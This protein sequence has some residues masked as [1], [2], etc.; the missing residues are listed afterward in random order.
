MRL[1]FF[2]SALNPASLPTRPESGPGPRISG[3]APRLSIAPPRKPVFCHFT[4]SHAQLK[5]RTFHR[6]CLPLAADGFEVR[7]LSPLHE[8]DSRSGVN[9]IPLPQRAGRWRRILDWPRLL[10]TLLRQKAALYHFQ[11][12]E[13]LPVAFVLKAVF[14]KR[15][16]YDAYEDFPSMARQTTS[17]PHV[18]RPSVSRCVAFA[19]NIAARFLDAVVT[20]DSQT[21]RRIARAGHSRKM[22]LY[23]FPNLDFF[24]SPAGSRRPKEFEL[25]YRGGLSERAGTFLLLEALRILRREGR[26]VRLL[27]I[28]YADTVAGEANL[29]KEIADSGLS[30][31]TELMSRIPHEEMAAALSRA[32]IGISPLLDTPKFRINIPVKVF[33]Y[34]ACGLPVVASDLRPLWPF[35]RSTN[36]GLLFPPGDAHALAFSIQ[37]L[38]DHRAEAEEMGRAGRSAIVRRFHNRAE[39]VRFSRFCR[40]VI[41]G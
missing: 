13:L 16:L 9:L 6:Q 11:D 25:V 2:M 41:A 39:A 29:R 1:F 24:P 36:A 22:V 3:P 40:H 32:R 26:V 15:V 4:L 5:S 19:E 14:R 7:Y 38:L 18:L 12:P 27:L 21:L 31:F 35:F 8:R 17:L 28:G 20:A 34:W 10:V 23:N 30:P 33:E 37:W